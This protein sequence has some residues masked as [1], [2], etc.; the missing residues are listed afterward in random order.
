MRVVILAAGKGTRMGQPFPKALT[1]VSGKPILERLLDSVRS[2]G[3]DPKP[4]V[5]IGHMGEMIREAIGDRCEY[6]EQGE[7]LGTG[8]AVL[9][10]HGLLKDIDAVLVLYGDHPFISP[11]SLQKI[12]EARLLMQSPISFATTIVPNFDGFHTAFLK[13]GRVLRDGNGSILGVREY[14]DATDEERSIKELNTGI[15]CFEAKW[16]WPHLEQIRNENTQKEY[17]LTDL[18]AMAVAEGLSINTI[19]VPPEEAMGINTPEEL[20]VAEGLVK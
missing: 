12:A 13:W 5:V 3:L 8:H 7:L 4:V 20:A 2:S 19:T 1:P 18:T 16:L 15:Y 17:Y 9:A 14:K 6:V 10:T 11:T